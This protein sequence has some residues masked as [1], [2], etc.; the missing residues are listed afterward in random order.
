MLVQTD[1]WSWNVQKLHRQPE[2]FALALPG[3]AFPGGNALAGVGEALTG[4]LR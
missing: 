4:G 1:A 2:T 3:L